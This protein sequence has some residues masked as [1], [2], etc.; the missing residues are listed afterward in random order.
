MVI[1]VCGNMK[2]KVIDFLGGNVFNII[3]ENFDILIKLI[4]VKVKK[5]DFV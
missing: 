2:I 1:D 4:L 5:I 3:V